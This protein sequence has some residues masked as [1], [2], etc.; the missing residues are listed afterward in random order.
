[1]K[2]KI[3]LFPSVIVLGLFLFTMCERTPTASFTHNSNSYEAR[4][5][6]YFKNT[7][8]DADAFKWDFGDGSTISTEKNPWHIYYAI[9]SFT[10]TLTSEN[11][12]GTD[13]D[14]QSFTIKDPTILGFYIT[15]DT[16]ETP[17]Q[18]C[19][20]AI[21]ESQSDMENGIN[22]AGIDIT[23]NEG[24]V[25]FYHVK[26]IVYY[27]YALKMETDGAWRFVGYTEEIVPNKINVYSVPAQWIPNKK[28]SAG[29]TD[30]AVLLKK[31]MDDRF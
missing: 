4:D 5:T 11:E 13:A 29:E 8:K 21:Y 17:V 27:I 12:H 16:T 23:D 19:T 6:I 26:A 24:I 3:I 7:S 9:G 15:Q 10:V 2:Q 30:K 22:E 14:N 25:A 20:V 28:V 1:M 31:I 18:E